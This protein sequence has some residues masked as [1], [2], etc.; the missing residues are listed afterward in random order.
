MFK[1][2]DIKCL[3]VKILLGLLKSYFKII[4]DID[5]NKLEELFYSFIG[6]YYDLDKIFKF[7][8]IYELLLGYLGLYIG[9]IDFE[10]LFD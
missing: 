8:N 5:S 9:N 1:K 4:K 7:E 3:I 2:D 6:K 10:E